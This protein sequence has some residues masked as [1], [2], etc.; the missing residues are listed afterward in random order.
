MMMM[1]MMM[2]SDMSWCE[3]PTARISAEKKTLVYQSELNFNSIVC[4][5]TNFAIKTIE[6]EKIAPIKNDL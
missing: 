6:I 4:N 2:Q 1:I 5:K 3:L